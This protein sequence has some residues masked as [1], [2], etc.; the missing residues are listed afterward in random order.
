MILYIV[1]RQVKSNFT[2]PESG[3]L[4]LKTVLTPGTISTT[5]MMQQQKHS[6]VRHTA[7]NVSFFPG[8]KKFE[9]KFF[10]FTQ[11]G[12]SYLLTW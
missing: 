12:D 1:Y 8:S 2:F 4:H 5:V 10:A 3:M 9:P 11:L 7:I 6:Q